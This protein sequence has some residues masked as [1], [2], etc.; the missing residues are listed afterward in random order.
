[1]KRININDN[2][3]MFHKENVIKQTILDLNH[4][5]NIL[6]ISMKPLIRV[7]RLRYSKSN[8]NENNVVIE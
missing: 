4:Y 1:M 8:I 3:K 6:Y 2:E 5:N 7:R